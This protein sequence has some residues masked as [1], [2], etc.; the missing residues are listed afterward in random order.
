MS[1]IHRVPQAKIDARFD[2]IIENGIY[3]DEHKHPGESMVS[4]AGQGVMY[5][6]VARASERGLG[7]DDMQPTLARIEFIINRVLYQFDH[8][9]TTSKGQFPERSTPK[10]EEKIDAL[11]KFNKIDF[12]GPIKAVGQLRVVSRTGVLSN[13]LGLSED[14]AV[15][16]YPQSVRVYLHDGVYRTGLALH[17]AVVDN[18][19]LLTEFPEQDSVVV[20]PLGKG[21]EAKLYEIVTVDSEPLR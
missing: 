3:N 6:L 10:V 13:S 8:L 5:D 20:V 17:G 18:N 14:G 11:L 2:K 15:F 1:E 21:S 4:F 7:Y 19:G 9:V 16:G 12:H